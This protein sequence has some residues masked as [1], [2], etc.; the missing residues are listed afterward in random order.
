MVRQLDA[1]LFSLQALVCYCIFDNLF[2]NH[3]N[4]ISFWLLVFYTI[5]IVFI[6]AQSVCLPIY[7]SIGVRRFARSTEVQ[8]QVARNVWEQSESIKFI[9]SN[10]IS[11]FGHMFDITN[12]SYIG[13]T[14]YVDGHFDRKE[15][16]MLEGI[17]NT[18]HAQMVIT[19][20]SNFFQYFESNLGSNILFPIRPLMKMNYAECK[21]LFYLESFKPLLD[22]PPITLMYL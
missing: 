1:H 6:I 3:R 21:Q 20:I 17:S 10:E 9:E 12:V 13:D 22:R 19:K 2:Y 14:V 18:H 5:V 16:A 7:K 11:Y 15:D 4:N 8:L